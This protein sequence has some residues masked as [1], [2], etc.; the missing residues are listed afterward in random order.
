MIGENVSSADN[1]QE[2][3]P[4]DVENLKYYLAGF[5]DGEGSF[6][7]TICKSNFAKLHWKI[8]PL[9]QVYQHKDNSRVLYIFK[10]VFDCGYV[11]K[12]GGNPSCFVYCVD[13]VADLIGKV[14]PFFESY[15]LVG[16]KY[17]NFLLFKEIVIGI[18][19]KRHLEPKGFIELA[20]LAFQMNR[21]G[22][23]RKN[24]LEKIISSLGQSSEAVRR[25]LS[26][27][28]EGIVRSL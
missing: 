10:D 21:M 5:T 6:S 3:V 14:I 1:Q 23:Y 28:E 15:P 8:D 11:S 25:T 4:E 13:K 18:S 26:V 17:N 9:F 2:R 27:D 19:N 22:Y 20:N 24:S 16:D 12:K 7:V